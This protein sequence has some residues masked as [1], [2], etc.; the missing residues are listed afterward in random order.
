M[1]ADLEASNTRQTRSELGCCATA[2]K[3]KE[4][5]KKERKKKERKKGFPHVFCTCKLLVHCWFLITL[6]S[7][8]S[9]TCTGVLAQIIQIWLKYF[10]RENS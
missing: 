10:Q 4:E 3:K 7:V 8:I 6:L 5:R 2:R 1:V 9:E